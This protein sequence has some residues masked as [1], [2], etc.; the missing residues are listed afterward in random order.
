M[1]PNKE[2]SPTCYTLNNVRR[3]VGANPTK[4]TKTKATEP[5]VTRNIK[6]VYSHHE[7]QFPNGGILLRQP[8]R[9]EACFEL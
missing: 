6:A 7:Q 4:G 5:H 3:K 2:C 9:D 1:H 8:E